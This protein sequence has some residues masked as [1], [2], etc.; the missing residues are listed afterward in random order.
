MVPYPAIS[1]VSI[2]PEGSHDHTARDARALAQGRLSALLALEVTPTGGRPPVETRTH[3]VLEKG[4]AAIAHR[5]DGRAY[6]LP[7]NPRRTVPRIY[8]D[9][10]FRNPYQDG[11]VAAETS[12]PELRERPARAADIFFL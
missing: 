12:I 4:R 3:L 9:L 5:E 8:S 10:I 2:H 1:L 7:P 11:Q 6:S